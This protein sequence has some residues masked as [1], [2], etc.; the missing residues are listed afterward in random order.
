MPCLVY[1][2]LAGKLLQHNVSA[3]EL[4][5]S[6]Y[7]FNKANS[8]SWIYFCATKMLTFDKGFTCIHQARK[9]RYLSGYI[10]KQ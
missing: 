10:N 1:D 8:V 6:L 2:F 4:P 9:G 3:G 7:S 5:T